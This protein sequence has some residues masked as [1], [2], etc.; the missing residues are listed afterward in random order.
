VD[1]AFLLLEDPAKVIWALG[2][3]PTALFRLLEVLEDPAKPRPR[4]ILGFPVGFVN[5]L[6]SKKRLQQ[7]APAPFIANISR[8]GGSNVAAAAV[9]ALA[10]LANRPG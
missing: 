6:E 9:N 3:A 2:N 10:R 4:L 1:A 5:A 8:K 7:A